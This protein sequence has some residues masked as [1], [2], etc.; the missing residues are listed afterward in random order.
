[1]TSQTNKN[2]ST[3]SPKRKMAQSSSERLSKIPKLKVPTSTPTDPSQPSHSRSRNLPS[4]TST[5]DSKHHHHHHEH[6]HHHGYHH[7]HH[8]LIHPPH[9]ATLFS[10]TNT[11]SNP[12]TLIQ[13]EAPGVIPPFTSPTVPLPHS[14][15]FSDQD[16]PSGAEDAA[17]L[18]AP[19]NLAS[20]LEEAL[21]EEVEKNPGLTEG[22]RIE[23]L[24][25]RGEGGSNLTPGEV[26]TGIELDVEVED[27]IT[28]ESDDDEE[29]DGEEEEV[30]EKDDEYLESSNSSPS[31]SSASS[32]SGYDDTSAA[33]N[34][35][36]DMG[37][38][39]GSDSD[40]GFVEGGGAYNAAGGGPSWNDMSNDNDT[41]PY[42]ARSAKVPGEHEGPTVFAWG[43]VHREWDNTDADADVE[44]NGVE[45][46]EPADAEAVDGYE[47]TG[48]GGRRNAEDDV[49]W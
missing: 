23:D 15:P 13:G 49:W 46:L 43:F 5:T 28:W 33:R 10:P 8:G 18:G 24:A 1:M 2:S 37:I 17:G 40:E 12:S 35:D 21:M 41:D 38:D 9:D 11:S 48:E 22:L 20:D 29:E 39:A 25:E 6:R 47:G 30:G 36:A 16:T 31:A 3:R 14:Q 44:W 26:G 7:P 27:E 19:P 34:L 32:D 42:A 4:K 45:A